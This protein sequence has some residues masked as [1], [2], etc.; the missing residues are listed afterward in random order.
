MFSDHFF[1]IF[2]ERFSETLAI[3]PIRIIRYKPKRE[4]FEGKPEIFSQ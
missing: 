2:L 1:L 3:A 4:S